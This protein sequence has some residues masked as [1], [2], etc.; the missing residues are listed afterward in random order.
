MVA[1]QH[2]AHL[3]LCDCFFW[4]LPLSFVVYFSADNVNAR[5]TV[6]HRPFAK[7]IF[8]PHLHSIAIG[9]DI[10]SEQVCVSFSSNINFH[11][12][13]SWPGRVTSDFD[14]KALFAI[15]LFFLTC[16]MRLGVSEDMD[17]DDQLGGDP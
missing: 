3:G 5:L 8:S 15:T 13:V 6:E 14:R 1:A 9:V 7:D 10:M 17:A 16:L 11:N 2:Q 4:A 12:R